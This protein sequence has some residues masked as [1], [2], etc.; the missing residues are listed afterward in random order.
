MST[1]II[2]AA[3]ILGCAAIVGIIIAI[4]HNYKKHHKKNEKPVLVWAY[5]GIDGSNAVED[6]NTQICDF[7]QGYDTMAYKWFKGDLS[8]WGYAYSDAKGLA[9]AFYQGKDGKWYGGKFEW[10]SSSRTTR[11]FKNLNSG[12]NGWDACAYHSAARH[13]FL[14]LSSDLKYRT[15]LAI[16]E[17]GG[18]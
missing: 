15:N 14:I 3:S 10:I 18:K 5:G 17:D 1:P 12:Y 4:V 9:C 7:V 16:A 6:P 11:S 2:I 8:N 13:G